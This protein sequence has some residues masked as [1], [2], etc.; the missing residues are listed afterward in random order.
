MKKIICSAVSAA[1]CVSIL[2]G[3]SLPGMGNDDDDDFFNNSYSTDV[4]EQKGDAYSWLVKP[5]ISA[6]N[7]ITFD[8]SQVNPDDEKN[9]A[10]SHYSVIRDNG[11]YGLI[12]YNGNIVVSAQYD[13][14]YTCSC[15]EITLFNVID[16][17]EEKYEYCTIDN[18][19]QVVNY[20]MQHEDKSPEYFWDS[21]NK[22]VYVKNKNSSSGTEYKGKKTVVVGEADI[23]EN[24]DG[25]FDITPKEA[26]FYGL[27]K[28]NKLILDMNYSDYYAPAYKGAGLTGIAL[29]DQSG[30]WG[31][32]GSDGNVI[33]DFKCDGDMNSYNGMII[34]DENVS[35]PYLFTGD[36]VPVLINASYGYYDIEG[37]CVVNPGEFEQARPVHNGRAWVR[38]DGLWGVIQLGEIV[39]EEEPSKVTTKETT[40]A[41]TYSYT[42][43]KKT[44]TG[45]S[46]TAV[47]QPSEK[48]TSNEPQHTTHAPVTDP[49]VTEQTHTDEPV[50]NP[51]ETDPPVNPDPPVDPPAEE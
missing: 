27:A 15:G 23:K 47:T 41:T 8:G 3:C 22:K 16:E 1:L 40:S 17:N 28:K 34:D 45:A 44:T 46:T 6:D 49:P 4:T 9:S 21:E 29:K 10:Y 36:Y 32:V 43:T 18:T 12:D 38:K 39:E 19:N 37:N 50:T 51:P 26:S 5:S 33:I 13:D 35:H 24:S 14:Y 7:I 11:K 2:A 42:T 31:Y 48:V 25:T 30:K 20:V